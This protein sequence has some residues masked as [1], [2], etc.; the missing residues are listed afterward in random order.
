MGDLEDPNRPLEI[1][2]QITNDYLFSYG[3]ISRFFRE[4][5][6]NQVLMATRCLGCG[7]VR[8]PPRTRCSECHGTAEWIELAGTGVVLAVTDCYFVP[9]NYAVHRYLKMPYTL[10]LIK[11]D[12]TDTALYN[13]VVTGRQDLHSVRPG[14]RVRATFRDRREGRLTDFYF[15][16]ERGQED[17]SSV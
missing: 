1:R 14:D 11:L 7:I 13:T 2:D 12:G 17:N 8:C 10:A 6:D 16:L 15:L 9:S 4:V 3:G 5:K